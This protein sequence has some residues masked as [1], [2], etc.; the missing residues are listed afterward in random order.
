[1]SKRR[2]YGA[3]ERLYNFTKA[4]LQARAAKS[5]AEA[6][7]GEAL[8]ACLLELSQIH[9]HHYPDCDGGCPTHHAIEQAK[10]ALAS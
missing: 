7:Y 1:M 4:Q 6:R 2:S 8:R 9:R 5:A 10:R 3:A